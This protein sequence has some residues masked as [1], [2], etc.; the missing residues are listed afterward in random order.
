MYFYLLTIFSFKDIKTETN[1][2]TETNTITSSNETIKE[3]K[4]D[5]IPLKKEKNKFKKKSF[6]EKMKSIYSPQS[7]ISSNECIGIINSRN[8]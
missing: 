3:I 5:S 2:I 7:L 6:W 8:N 1:P 4:S